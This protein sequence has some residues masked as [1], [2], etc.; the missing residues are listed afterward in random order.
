MCDWGRGGRVLFAD[1]HHL[2]RRGAELLLPLA[3]PDLT[4]LLGGERPGG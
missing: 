4:W 1:E 3:R 2:S